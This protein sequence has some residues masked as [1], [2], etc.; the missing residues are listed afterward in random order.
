MPLQPFPLV[1]L[2]PNFLQGDLHIIHVLEAAFRVFLQA[3]GDD[4]LQLLRDSSRYPADRFGLQVRQ[5]LLDHEVHSGTN[6]PWR[7]LSN[8]ELLGQAFNLSDG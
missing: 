2:F 1:P 4:Q 6:P 8:G 5:T 7:G 3:T